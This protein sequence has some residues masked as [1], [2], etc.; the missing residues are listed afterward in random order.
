MPNSHKSFRNR[1][2]PIES[3]VQKRTFTGMDAVDHV[4]P[5]DPQ[6]AAKRRRNRRRR[7]IIYGFLIASLCGFWLWQPWEYDFIERRAPHP[8]PMIDPNSTSLFSRGTKVLIVT[9]HPDDSEFYVGGTLAKLRDSGAEIHQ[10][11]VT[12]GDKAYYGPL[13]DVAR[14]R[15][16]RRAE[17]LA[18]ARQWGGKSLVFLGF[19]DGRLGISNRLVLRLR[20]EID[21]I[22]PDYVLAFDFDYP[23]RL[24]HKDHRV[25]GQAVA[26]ALDGNPG[27]KWLMRFSTSH[28]NYVVDI[29]DYWPEK[30]ELLKIHK[31]QFFGKRLVQVTNMVQDRAVEDAEKIEA[32]YG[33]GFR[34]TPLK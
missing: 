34:A 2:R 25:A 19:Q 6:R 9:A 8:N 13:T 24:S 27:V 14:N 15:R 32:T 11:I 28:P 7:I 17:A 31:S 1:D 21:K 10:V 29:S 18:A 5:A 22:K 30:E 23:P 33:E 12:D 16:E 26:L 4:Q 20:E 3:G